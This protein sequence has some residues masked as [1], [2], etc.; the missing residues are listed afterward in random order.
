M[1]YPEL[2][3]T[4]HADHSLSL[5]GNHCEAARQCAIKHRLP[6]LWIAGGS[7]DGNGYV[8][9]QPQGWPSWRGLVDER[10]APALDLLS[11]ALLGVEGRDW[12]HLL[13]IDVAA[14]AGDSK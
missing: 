7:L 11:S 10:D 4:T 1:H 13:P 5:E 9:V 8:Y 3:A 6:G 12:F 14:D 2:S